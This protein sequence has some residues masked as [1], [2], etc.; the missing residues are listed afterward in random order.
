MTPKKPFNLLFVAMVISLV[1]HGTLFF[2]TVDSTYDAFVH[3]FFGDHYA[4]NWFDTWDNRWYT[5]FN[6]T[7][8]PPLVHQLTG[9]LSK[10]IGLRNAFLLLAAIVMQI[11]MV[12]MYRFSLLWTNRRAAGY[13]AILTCFG[14]SINEAFHL[15]GQIPTLFGIA[16]LLNSLPEIYRWIRYGK[17]YRLATAIT[18]MGVGVTSHHVTTIFGMVFFVA[19]VIG[20]AVLDSILAKGS[21]KQS[22]NNQSYSTRVSHQQ[23]VY[24]FSFFDILAEV[25]I[26]WKEIVIFGACVPIIM[27]LIFPYF[28]WSA[29]D[30]I[31]Q[32]SIP[33]GSRDS[34]IKVPSSGLMFFLIPLGVQLLLL[35]YI[36]SR[37]WTKRNMFIGLS[38]TLL[39]ILGTGGTTPIPIMMLGKNAF[40]ILTLDRFTFWASI[41]GTPFLGEFFYRVVEG[42][43]RDILRRKYGTIVYRLFA[44]FLGGT[45]AVLTIFIVSLG[46]FRPL[47]PPKIDIKPIVQFLERDNHDHWRYMTLGFG[48]QMAWL[49]AQT[50]AQS[51]DG[52]YHSARRLPEMTTRPLERLENSKF[53]GIEGI[54]SLQQF[55][56]VPEKYFLKFIFSNDKFYDPIL[57]FSGWERVQRLENGIMVW[58]KQ[59]IPPLPTVLPRKDLPK[60]IKLWW[61]IMPFFSLTIAF[62]VNFVLLW[63]S[64]VRNLSF[65]DD[66]YNDS[67]DIVVPPLRK[68]TLYFLGAWIFVVVTIVTYVSFKIAS[69]SPYQSPKDVVVAYYDAV[70]F[71]YF[72]TAHSYFD[73]SDRPEFDDYFVKLSVE[74]GILASYAKLNNLKVDLKKITETKYEAHI[75]AEWITPVEEYFTE[76]T[77]IVIKNKGKWY[78][79]AP[80]FDLSIPADQFMIEKAQGIHG[81]G[82]RQAGTSPTQHDDV[83]DRPE[84]QILNASLVKMDS[85][86]FVIGE[87]QNVDAY[88]AHITISAQLYDKNNRKL[89]SYN[90]KFATIHRILPLEKI[91]FKVAF[92]ST[93]WNY[94][95]EEKS[96][97][98]NPNEFS[99][100]KYSSAPT[101]FK[102][103]ARAVVDKNDLYRSYDIQNL[104][105][106]KNHFE[107][108]LLNYGTEEISVPKL[109]IAYSDAKG[110]LTWLDTYFMREGVR[111]QRKRDFKLPFI[112]FKDFAVIKIGENKDFFV[113][114]LPNVE[115]L[116]KKLMKEDGI[117]YKAGWIKIIPDGY[118]ANPTLY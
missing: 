49:S 16:C 55:L 117:K 82:K 85:S 2:F 27:L 40:N 8:Y 88:P 112:N 51:V 73:P 68:M 37:V 25:R 89:V 57:Y 115:V 97:K 20:L 39:F 70:D 38:F 92:E 94:K 50:K 118:I 4:R 9:F 29:T 116:N 98:F 3:M 6:V 12:G 60:I 90:A 99:P 7:S 35:P 71:K 103:L 19:P 74:D 18:I 113:N 100:F 13:A 65:Y 41:I 26:K 15:F 96:I 22:E 78:L 56:T 53:K 66:G 111:P 93:A 32:V 31:T 64:K 101:Q 108:S 52:N 24:N 42:D 86:Y 58:Q 106:T 59:D 114:G 72:E 34:F 84:L 62:L 105:A 33:H 17:I 87:L 75:V 76:A 110:D 83:L 48:D 44:G 54:G 30:P 47:Q 91:P 67:D 109:L 43:Y 10:F 107:G 81:H 36:F 77:H 69:F 79:K 1:F 21:F 104:K 45:V 46:N 102:L 5:G 95:N 28:Y 11:L 63:Y 61:G 80:K 14:A 23:Q